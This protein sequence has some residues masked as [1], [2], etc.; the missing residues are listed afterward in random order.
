MAATNGVVATNQRQSLVQRERERGREKEKEGER[1]RERGR[2]RERERQKERGRKREIYMYIFICI[3]I[4]AYTPQ[5][6]GWRQQVNDKSIS[7]DVPLDELYAGTHASVL[8]TR[9]V[10]FVGLFRP[11]A[12]HCNNLQHIATHCNTLQHSVLASM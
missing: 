10:V 4:C 9:Q 1:K 8:V 12:T 3:H 2:G 5:T 6:T 11:S 7:V